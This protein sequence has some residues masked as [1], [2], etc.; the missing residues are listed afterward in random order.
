MRTH[1]TP[2][3]SRL[4]IP[5]DNPV[6]DKYDPDQEKHREEMGLPPRDEKPSYLTDREWEHIKIQTGQMQEPS[7]WDGECK[8]DCCKE[9]PSRG[10][11][12]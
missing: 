5:G 12:L 10:Y 2:Q 7:A 1:D 4:P 6:L 9:D 3:G 11:L 8:G